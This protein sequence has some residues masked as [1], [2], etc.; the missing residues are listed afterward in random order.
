[1]ANRNASEKVSAGSEEGA[2]SGEALWPAA[3]I[4]TVVAGAAVCDLACPATATI[5]DG[6]NRTPTT[7]AIRILLVPGLRIC[8]DVFRRIHATGPD[9]GYS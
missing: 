5:K 7:T 9:C 2:E 1:V 4:S 8:L 3:L 6:T